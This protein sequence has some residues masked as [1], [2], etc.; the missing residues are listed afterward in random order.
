MDNFE[1]TR[2]NRARRAAERRGL[3]L[4]RS[5]RRDPKAIGYGQYQLIDVATGI[6][7]SRG[8][9][10]GWLTMDQVE[11]QLRMVITDHS[12]AVNRLARA[13]AVVAIEI[14]PINGL[15]PRTLARLKP[16]VDKAAQLLEDGTL[17][18]LAD[19]ARAILAA[20]S[21]A[22]PDIMKVDAVLE[23]LRDALN[24]Y[25]RAHPRRSDLREAL[26]AARIEPGELSEAI[27][28]ATGR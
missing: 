23:E 1:K 21:A 8:G 24:A 22:P 16:S 13:V 15:D 5:R 4:E 11:A 3:R 27:R 25:D 12:P 6:V 10:G 2:E 18:E 26:D 17:D 9:A 20:P 14:V 7:A 19:A 28:A